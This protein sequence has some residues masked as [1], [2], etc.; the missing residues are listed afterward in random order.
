MSDETPSEVERMNKASQ[1][2][3]PRRAF[4]CGVIDR[5]IVAEMDDIGTGDGVLEL[6]DEV[7]GEESQELERVNERLLGPQVVKRGQSST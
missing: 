2:L 3:G 6:R 1:V 7:R 4:N 5:L